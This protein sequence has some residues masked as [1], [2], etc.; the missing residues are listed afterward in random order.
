[1]PNDNDAPFEKLDIESLLNIRQWV[2]DAVEAKGAKVIGTGVG[3]K[4]DL[5]M[6]DIDIAQPYCDWISLASKDRR[7]GKIWLCKECGHQ[8]KGREVPKCPC[9]PIKLGDAPGQ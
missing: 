8:G 3:V 7:R 2:Q 6:A 1:M 4:H 5:G 9:A